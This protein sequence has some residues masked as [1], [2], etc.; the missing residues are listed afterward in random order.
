MHKAPLRCMSSGLSHHRVEQ[1]K[2][3]RPAWIV[4]AAGSN[5][6]SAEPCQLERE[7]LL[8]AAERL[9]Q[10]TPSTPQGPHG[11]CGG[12]HLFM[13]HHEGIQL[14]VCVGREHPGATVW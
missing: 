3:M 14:D 1:T 10:L 8:V 13:L 7:S 4:T 9:H 12:Q 5:Y 6:S 2:L 11:V